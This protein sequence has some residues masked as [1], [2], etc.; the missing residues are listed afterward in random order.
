MALISCVFFFRLCTRLG[1]KCLGTALFSG[2]QAIAQAFVFAAPAQEEK[3]STCTEKY[4][5]Y[6]HFYAPMELEAGARSG[7]LPLIYLSS[8]PSSG[9]NKLVTS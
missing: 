7:G 3:F 1:V 5:L 6:A 2:S 4:S 8:L 9:T